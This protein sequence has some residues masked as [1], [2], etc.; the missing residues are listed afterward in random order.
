M[1][2][3]WLIILNIIVSFIKLLTNNEINSK[4]FN[5]IIVSSIKLLTTIKLEDVSGANHK[6]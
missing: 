2:T 5:S 6:V 1:G 4:E 3:Q